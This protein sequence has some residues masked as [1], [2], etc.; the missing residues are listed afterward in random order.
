M[1]MPFANWLATFKD[2]LI[3]LLYPNSCWV[4]GDFFDAGQARL[5]P[6]CE[7]RLI[8]DPREA[9]PRCGSSVGP[10]VPLADG[11]SQCRDLTLAYDRVLRLGPY[12]NLLR[13]VIIRLKNSREESLAQVI[14]GV[15]ARLLLLRL[16]ELSPQAV[17]PVPLHWTRRY[18]E[19]GFNQS[20]ILA[21]CL[22]RSLRIPCYPKCVRRL[23]RTPRQTYQ[24]SVAARR[25]NVRGAFRARAGY[26]LA[27]KTVL[28]VDD[29]VTTGATVNEVARALKVLKPA[30]IVV[31]VLAHG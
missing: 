7:H 28:V 23:R 8:T 22:A 16:K 15:W 31:A 19:R 1:S 2:G 30:R 18:W 14:G 6:T 10:H 11:C 25:E 29:V 20:E 26:D 13:E 4:C 17:V 3:Q 9:C 12:E 27:G 24:L 5:C 21:R